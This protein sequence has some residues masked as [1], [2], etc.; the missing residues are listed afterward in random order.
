MTIR[1]FS[2]PTAIRFG[3]GAS[4]EVRAHLQ[5]ERY[6]RPL[7][8]TD[9][10]LAQLPLFK[11]FLGTLAPLDAA[12]YSG[13]SGNP[14]EK[15]VADGAK[16][17]HAHRADCIV[18]IGGGAALDVAKAIALMTHH[19]GGILD[20]EDGK[21]DARPIDR[22]IPYWVALPTTSGTGSEVG[23]STV[24]SDAHHVKRIV[25]HP[26]LLAKVVFADPL[27]TLDLPAKITAATGMDAITHC[28][29]A[30]LAKDHHP[31]CDGIALEGLKLAAQALPRCV[32]TPKDV[33]ARS[34]MMMA[35]M[36]GAIAFQKG[37]GVAHSCAHALGQA[38]D[39]HHGLAC[40]IMI[41][42]AT[43]MNAAARPERFREMARVVRA[44]EE[45]PEGFLRWMADLK[46]QI[47]IPAKLSQA[48]LGKEHLSAL[49][50]MALADSC[51]QNNPV[52]V[53]I[54]DFERIFREA[55]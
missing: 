15:H 37:L 32:A 50:A 41:D 23:R 21:P 4:R 52:P 18:G 39:M 20:Y 30:Y 6:E 27:L 5:L 22:E 3:P 34:D 48:G 33:E 31:I 8:V 44:K 35:S 24:I 1:S 45:T 25:F 51:H 54:G 13:V 26:R 36:M 9:A 42:H 43:R 55:W 2:F 10:G 11:D 38:A 47:G 17:F 40:G 46:A 14:V 7:V 53:A 29:E 19:A 12:V 16:A 49:P 28:V